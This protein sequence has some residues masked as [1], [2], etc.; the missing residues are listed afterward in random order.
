MVSIG[1]LCRPLAAITLVAGIVS[2]AGLS[3][4]A[5]R[6]EQVRFAGGASSATISGSISGNDGVNYR[7]GASSGQVMQVLFSPSSNSCFMNVIAPGSDVAM[8]RGEIAGNEF[9]ANLRQSGDYTVQV[10]L[11]RNAAR[12]GV[13]CDYQVSFEIRGRQKAS[14]GLED[15]ADDGQGAL[16]GARFTRRDARSACE[17]GL[18]E[19]YGYR[20]NAISEVNVDREG[21]DNFTVSGLVQR[22]QSRSDTFTC[23]VTHG[24]VISL[25]VHGADTPGD[26]VGKSVLGAVLLG[27]A[28]ALA[29]TDD[30]HEP[31]PAYAGG[32]PFDSR[33]HLNDACRHEI[34]RN[35]RHSH[36][37][38]DSVRIVT[39]HLRNRVLEGT[40]TIRWSNTDHMMHYTCEFDRRGRLVDGSF[41]YY[42][43]QPAAYSPDYADGN[44]GGPDSLRVTGVAGNDTLYVHQRPALSSPRV[45]SLPSNARGISS[46]GCQW[47]EH[48]HGTWCEVEFDGIRGFAAQRYLAEDN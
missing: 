7:L 28:V 42:P 44:A 22:Y 40:G 8:H 9:S 16:D 18:R 11:N 38:F 33:P 48:D 30:D 32:N 6:N 23:R 39:S 10:F 14:S 37:K 19:Q 41:Y 15:D 21:R 5:D 3:Q 24:E 26:A 47:S 1:L 4:A 20:R 25:R 13:T 34:A 2:A 31:Y 43:A 36:A 29:D 17:E 35:L 12:R 27:T 45:G 46:R